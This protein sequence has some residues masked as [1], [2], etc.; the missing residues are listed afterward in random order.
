[1]SI[2]KLPCGVY[3]CVSVKS[4]RRV[5]SCLPSPT[6]ALVS[7]TPVPPA[8]ALS[9]SCSFL[10]YSCLLL[11]PA[12][13]Y[14]KRRCQQN[15]EHENDK[16]P[17]SPSPAL[18]PLFLRMFTLPCSCLPFPASVNPPLL[19]SPLLLIMSALFYSCLPSP[20][21]V[22]LPYSYA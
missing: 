6:P 2:Y 1:V 4:G 20:D 19:L 12:L 11:L 7:P 16:T 14:F 3:N 13:P 21:H 8:P 18:S 22:C 5:C 9:C 10:P 17:V 15:Q